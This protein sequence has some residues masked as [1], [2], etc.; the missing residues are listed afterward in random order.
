MFWIDIEIRDE[1]LLNFADRVDGGIVS[2]N[3][4]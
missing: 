4:V 3:G 2:R 1:T